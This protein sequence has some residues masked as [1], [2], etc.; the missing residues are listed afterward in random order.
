[1][2]FDVTITFRSAIVKL[3][4][5]WDMNDFDDVMM[6]DKNGLQGGKI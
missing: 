4:L 6:D 3:L 1:L 5:L 2:T